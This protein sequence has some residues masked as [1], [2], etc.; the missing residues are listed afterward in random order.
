LLHVHKTHR[1][2][3][4]RTKL[5]DNNFYGIRLFA[6]RD[7]Q[8]AHVADCRVNGVDWDPG[9]QAVAKYVSSWP[10]LGFEFRKQYVVLHTWPNRSNS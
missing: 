4:D 2:H 1:H 9:K 7:E 10:D 8:G 6:M 5:L 3:Y